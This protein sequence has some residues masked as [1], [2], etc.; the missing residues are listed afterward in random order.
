MRGKDRKVFQWRTRFVAVGDEPPSSRLLV[1]APWV[2]DDVDKCS[3][4]DGLP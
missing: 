2:V 3:I 4:F 1:S